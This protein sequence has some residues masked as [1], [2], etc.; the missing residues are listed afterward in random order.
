MRWRTLLSGAAAVFLAAPAMA[1]AGF[2]L[3]N[4]FA[5]SEGATVSVQASFSDA[6]PNP[7]VA[8]VSDHFAIHAPDD[9]VLAFDRIETLSALT[10]LEA[11]LSEPGQYRLTTGE[12][13]GRKGEI[14]RVSGDYIR[15]GANGVSRASVPGNAEILSAQTAT[16]SEAFVTV[17]DVAPATH[18]Q[19]SGRLSISLSCGDP[20]CI[21]R[22]PLQ[23]GLVFDQAPLAGADLS[24][25]TAYGKYRGLGD[26][27]PFLTGPDGQ[28]NL[29]LLPAGV[30]VLMARHIAPAPEGAQTDL[31]SYSTTLTFE[32]RSN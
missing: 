6:F 2:L 30:Y 1:H 13:L 28:T 14:A 17:G 4:S 9:H 24:L 19:T 29:P 10:V 25:I 5:V 20:G 7:D 11:A 3:P 16:V 21:K 27:V 22:A 8:L 12:R 32:I 26:G 23:A 18:L 31:R 15:L